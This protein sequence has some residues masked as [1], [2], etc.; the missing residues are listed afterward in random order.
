MTNRPLVC[1]YCTG[2]LW[3]PALALFVDRNGMLV[4]KCMGCGDRWPLFD[5]EPLESSP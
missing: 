5:L 3:H 1:W 4:T 2:N